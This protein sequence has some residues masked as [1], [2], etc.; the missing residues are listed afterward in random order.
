MNVKK[1]KEMIVAFRRTKSNTISVLGEEVEVENCRYLG[2]HLDARYWQN[3]LP[4]I[5]DMF[6]VESAAASDQ[7]SEENV[8]MVG[9]EDQP[10]T[11]QLEDSLLYPVKHDRPRGLGQPVT[12]SQKMRGAMRIGTIYCMFDFE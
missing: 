10:L 12:Q 2:V 6:V 1:K 9:A 7:Q 5:F 11:F 8:N 3:R 4:H